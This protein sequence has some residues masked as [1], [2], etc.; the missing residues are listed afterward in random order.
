MRFNNSLISGQIEDMVV[1]KEHGAIAYNHGDQT[2]DYVSLEE[3]YLK[4]EIVSCSF[5]LVNLVK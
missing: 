1:E 3:Y 4:E 2:M 5:M